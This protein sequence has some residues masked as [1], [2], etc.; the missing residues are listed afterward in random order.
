MINLSRRSFLKRSALASAGAVLA[1]N[2]LS[3]FAKT[4]KA[5]S[6]PTLMG[7]KI[8][9]VWGGGVERA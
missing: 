6:E 8:L 7:K 2:T 3:T 5:T 1:N 4:K 9:F